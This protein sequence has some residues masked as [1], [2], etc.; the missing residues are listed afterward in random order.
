[1]TQTLRKSEE[2]FINLIVNDLNTR[3]SGDFS[4]DRVMTARPSREFIIGCLSAKFTEANYQRTIAQT[5]S[6]A[7]SFLVKKF[8]KF[9]FDLNFNVYY[10]ISD[11]KTLDSLDQMVWKKKKMEFKGVTVEKT[12]KVEKEKLSTNKFIQDIKKDSDLKKAIDF[13]WAVNVDVVTSKYSQKGQDLE[14]VTIYIQNTTPGDQLVKGE[15][16]PIREYETS[17]FNVEVDIKLDQKIEKFVFDYEYEGEP[18]EYN[19][20]LRTLNCGAEYYDKPG[21]IKTNFY[22]SYA[23]PLIIPKNKLISLDGKKQKEIRFEELSEPDKTRALLQEIL[24]TMEEYL[25]FHK[26]QSKKADSHYKN[27]TTDFENVVKKFKRG[28]QSLENPKVMKAFNLMQQ[29]FYGKENDLK[30]ES[31]VT[32][33]RLF[34]IVYIVTLIPDIVDVNSNHEEASVLHVD[35]GGGKSEAYF[36]LIVFSAFL[37]RLDGKIVGLTGITKFPLRMLSVQQ[38]QRIAVIFAWAEEVRKIQKID[39]PFSIGYFVGD[40][41]DFPNT[42]FKLLAQVIAAQKKGKPLRGRI[43]NDCPICRSENSVILVSEPVQKL[44]HHKC[45]KCDRE[46]KFYLCDDEIYRTLPTFVVATV[47][48]FAGIGSQRKIKNLFGG[49]LDFCNAKHGFI[50]RNDIC[51]Y[52]EEAQISCKESGVP[53]QIKYSTAPRLIIQDEMHLIREAFGSIDSHFESFIEQMTH[54]FTGKYFKN[55]AMTATICG[56]EDQ[57]SQLYNKKT[58]IF[59]NE[60]PGEKG[61]NDFFFEKTGQ[62]QRIIIGMTPNMRDNQYASLLTIRYVV[63]FIANIENNKTAFCSKSGIS[64]EDL[65]IILYYY[66]TYLTYHNKISDVNQMEYFLDAVVSSKLTSTGYSIKP[67]RLTSALTIDEIKQIINEIKEWPNL[68]SKEI[69]ISFATNLVSHGVDIDKW[70]IMIFQGIPRDTAE[71]IQALSRAGRKHVG[72]IIDWFYPTKIRDQSYFQNFK[73]YHEILYHHVERVPISRW[74]KLAFHQTFNTLFCG[75]ILN[76]LSNTLE[77]P[78]YSVHN[79]KT[80]LSDISNLNLVKEFMKKAYNIKENVPGSRYFLDQ[81]GI[82]VERRHAYIMDYKKAGKRELNFFPTCLADNLDPYF[83]MQRGMRGIQ[84]SIELEAEYKDD[85]FVSTYN[86]KYLEDESEDE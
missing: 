35:T 72:L 83:K 18:K 22:K 60:N 82:E 14:L 66:K 53:V 70:N 84:D 62:I 12:G 55:V 47:D 26:T 11:V 63:E 9:S 86:Q 61:V 2:K 39:G 15:Y 68:E 6:L 7:I 31:R 69:P 38:L 81:I 1:M 27:T 80:Y 71:Y 13:K 23:Q 34:Q 67:Y 41:K 33:W 76:Y 48:K 65:D 49:K 73:E 64:K 29:T 25:E 78:I 36:G 32:S 42:N 5:N 30:N 50:P 17:Y 40:N 4:T 44:I 21:S 58:N 54:E 10:P 45:K 79:Y 59:P 46:F 16:K 51:K 56:A 28:M 37:D 20:W 3:L 8:K 52:Q 24:K 85:N 75:A 77:R 43:I 74:A 19:T 57:I